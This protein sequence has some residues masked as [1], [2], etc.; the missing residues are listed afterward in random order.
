MAAVTDDMAVG[1][2]CTKRGIYAAQLL[3]YLS[4]DTTEHLMELDLVTNALVLE[5]A[6]FKDK[7]SQLTFKLLHSWVKELFG[8][9]WPEQPPTHQA[10]SRSIERL[11]A[12]LSKLKKQSSSEEKDGIIH[13]F[14]QQEFVL[15][16]LGFR[17]GRIVRFS[18]VKRSSGKLTRE[19]Q[20]LKQKM[21][22]VTRNANKR[23]KR[24]QVIIEQQKSCI[25]QQKETIRTYEKQL[26][27]LRA[28]I[29][30]VN[31]RA[32]YWRTR[33]DRVRQ[34]NSEKKAELYQELKSLKEEV[35]TLDLNNAELNETIESILS[36]E[37]ISTFEGGKYT[38]DVR[39]CIYELLS[40]NVGVRNVAPIIR[41]VLKGIAH[42]SVGR[43]PSY[44]LTCQMILESLTVAQAQLGEKLSDSTNNTLQT[45]GT[46]KFGDHFATYDIKASGDTYTLGLRHVFS[47][48]AGDTLQTFKDI[49]EDIDDVHQVLGKDPVSAKIVSKI[50]NTM[51]DRHAA[52]KL[53]NELLHDYR[54]EL[55]PD[56]CENWD[57]MTELERENLTR[58]NNFFCGLHYMVGL[59]D[60]AEE[61]LKVWEAQ[62][63]EEVGNSSGTQRLIRTACKAFHHRGS[64]QSGSSALFR[65]FLRRVGIHKI[66]LA[67]FVGNRFNIIFYDAAGVHYL[68][69][70]MIKF[71]ET[72]HGKQANRL[73]HAVLLDL[74][75]STNI[76]GCR[77]LGIIDKVVTGP[78]WRKLNESS[79]SVLHMSSVYTRIKNKFD[80]WSDSS[81]TVLQGREFLED[82]T[83]VHEDEVWSTLLESDEATDVATQELLQLLFKSFSKTTQR[84]LLDHLPGGEYNAVTDG[85]LITETASVPVTNVSPER[86]FAVLDRLLREKPNAHLIALESLILYSHNKTAVWLEQKTCEEKQRLFKAAQT[87]A[88]QIREKF[89]VR[90]QDICSRRQAALVKK[91]EE[92]A[93]KEAREV[94]EKE[95]LTKEIEHIG[96]LWV[97]RM[98]VESS[99]CG[100]SRTKQLSHLKLQIKFRHKVLCQSHPDKSVFKFSQNRKQHSVNVLKQNLFRLLPEESFSTADQ[101]DVDSPADHSD[102]E[103]SILMQPELL[104]GRRIRHRFEVCGDLL[105]Y[106]GTILKMNESKEFEVLYDDEEDAC[107]FPLL[108]DFR[109]GDLELL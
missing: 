33:M 89:K 40:L 103:S 79:A 68:R 102:T 37:E 58:M 97:T 27:K 9:S 88:P 64:Q 24:R 10:I 21:Y 100:V 34:E 2:E 52:E 17:S 98:D 20:E 39:A 13:E 63:T 41:S 93:R 74:K 92:I 4:K 90:R 84:L 38:D 35:A 66:P 57:Q 95:K 107:W 48:S 15:P 75:N 32:S 51:S 22:A 6:H 96:G 30:R 65:A 85:S 14:L 101:I 59:A 86:D 18:P 46:T 87:L 28:K 16:R 49:L 99:L 56:I 5:L 23:L 25:K 3:S 71:I 80:V 61:T 105:W 12:K 36:S 70:H 109:A 7:H 106:T 26:T 8:T 44:G 82:C 108:E 67:Q 73:L 60:T 11:S 31:H 55:L 104:V 91:Q 54:A 45:D 94:E 29:D 69:H 77:A 19:T 47:G 76:A 50:K 42:K 72:A 62:C 83:C 1:P 81:Y 78:L 43:L 53:F